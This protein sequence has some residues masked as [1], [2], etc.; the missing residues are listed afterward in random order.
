MP[1]KPSRV[2]NWLDDIITPSGNALTKSQFCVSV[3]DWLGTIGD[4]IDTRPAPSKIDAI[5][6]L[7]MSTI[8]EGVGG[9]QEM[10]DYL[11]KFIPV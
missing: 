10:G 4:R 11:R 2:C 9:L 8:V 1:M 3:M 5:T 6:P 7:S